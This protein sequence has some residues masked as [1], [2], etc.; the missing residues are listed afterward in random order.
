MIDISL[1]EACRLL[2]ENDNYVIY[3]HAN[4]DGDTI[5]SGCALALILRSM[6]K[7][8]VC[9]CFDAI[10]KRL[11]FLPTELFVPFPTDFS[12]FTP[13]S[14]DIAGPKMLGG[15]APEFLLSIDHHK[16]NTVMCKHRLLMSE[17][18]AA[19][20]IIY[21]LMDELGVALTKEIALC[22]Y[23]AICSDSGGFQYDATRPETHIAAARCIETG[24]DFAYVNRM[25]FECKTKG[26]LALERIAYNN[27]TFVCGGKYA[28]VFVTEEEFRQSGAEESDC[29]SL[30][31]IPRQIE[32]V[33]ASGMIRVKNGVVKISLRSNVDI[34]VAAIAA[35]HGGGGHYHAAGFSLNTGM[36]EARAVIEK[37]FTEIG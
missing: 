23:T 21:M 2:S 28:Y 15:D 8:A 4:P 1:K 12:D 36:D 24:I 18:I 11:S 27:L 22:L 7:N 29:G 5:G 34:D 14:V 6:G 9:T 30:N 17:L 16:I 35:S 26:Q 19:G 37:I 20:E 32:G 13:I 25:L 31:S 33:L 3:T 10:P